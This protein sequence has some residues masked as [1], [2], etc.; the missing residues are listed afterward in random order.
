M[1]RIPLFATLLVGL[2]VVTMVALGLWQLD[3]KHW[4]D[5][6]VERYAAASGNR[7]EVAFPQTKAER[8]A[9][10]YRKSSVECLRVE[11][12][13]AIS[14]RNAAG[15]AGW[16]Y[17]VRCALRGGGGATVVLGW[18]RRPGDADWSEGPV[19]G[20]IGP[21]ADGEVRLIAAPPLAGLAANATPDPREVPNNHLS[22][23]VQWF[24]FAICAAV[25][26]ALAVWKRLAGSRSTG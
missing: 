17:T 10:L 19:S 1:K 12:R 7:D 9:A 26:Y 6:L 3:R 24:L 11:S 5:A 22:Y 25:I 16:A 8:E 13:Q 14:G 21:G 20:V 2:A 15:E 23:A 4:K 18:S